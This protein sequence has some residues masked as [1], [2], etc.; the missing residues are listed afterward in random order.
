MLLLPSWHWQCSAF[1][2]NPKKFVDKK[3]I[4]I[5]AVLKQFNPVGQERRARLMLMIV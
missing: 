3:I 1:K 2:K 5:F 4:L